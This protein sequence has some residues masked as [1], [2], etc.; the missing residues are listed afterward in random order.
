M[1]DD[2]AASKWLLF[3]C[4]AIFVWMLFSGCTIKVNQVFPGKGGLT[5]YQSDE[6]TVP[7]QTSA[8]VSQGQAN[9]ETGDNSA[10]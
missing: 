5:V 2:C 1:I 6:A 4:S 7:V 8:A 3:W 10:K 9:V